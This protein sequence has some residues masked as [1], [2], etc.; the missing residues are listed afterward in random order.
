MDVFQC[1]D[2]ITRVWTMK[3]EVRVTSLR[4]AGILAR[5]KVCLDLGRRDGRIGRVVVRCARY[6]SRT[7][8]GQESV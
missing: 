4:M 5:L 1:A 8:D 3:V 7:Y 6:G 2:V